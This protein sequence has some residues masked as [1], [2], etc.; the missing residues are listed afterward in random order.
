MHR[1]LRGW[2]RDCSEP[3]PLGVLKREVVSKY[4]IEVL[5][6]ASPAGESD[7]DERV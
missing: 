2:I 5:L 3:I 4:G 1:N 7:L 6:L